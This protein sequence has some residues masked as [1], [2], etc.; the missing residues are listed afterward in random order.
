MA[1]ASRKLV[2]KAKAGGYTTTAPAGPAER[3]H[4]P[5]AGGEE[6]RPDTV[7]SGWRMPT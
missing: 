1:K 7:P 6:R 4:R 5:S 3:A 2:A